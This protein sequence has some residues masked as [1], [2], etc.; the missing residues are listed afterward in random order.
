MYDILRCQPKILKIAK[1]AFNK[2]LDPKIF[3]FLF[4]E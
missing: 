4:D 2:K 1:D 3:P